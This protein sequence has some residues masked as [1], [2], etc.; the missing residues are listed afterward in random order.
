MRG[1]IDQ[2]QCTGS[3]M[4]E[5]AVPDVFFLEDDL[6]YVK[7]EETTFGETKMF[8]PRVWT[9]SGDGRRSAWVPAGQ[10]DAVLEASKDCPG[11]CI[12]IVVDD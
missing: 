11:E 1:W 7:E 8:S 2:D 12:F 4:C 3:G 9:S 6:A 5:D 10:E